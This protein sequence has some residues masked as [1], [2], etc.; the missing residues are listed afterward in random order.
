MEIILS[1]FRDINFDWLA[2]YQWLFMLI[3][4]IIGAFFILFLLSLAVWVYRDIRTRSRDPLAIAFFILLVL[5]LN[6]PGL[7]F[8]L[9]LRPAETL[10]ES[11]ERSLHEEALLRELDDQ[12]S[13]PSCQ[14]PIEAEFIMCPFCYTQ[15]KRPCPSCRRLL[16]PSWRGCP[17]CGTRVAETPSDGGQT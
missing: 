3:A 13:C 2:Q 7:V 11:Y 8:Y 14:R 17:Y 6:L 9:L 16:S 1:L 4:A 10:A 12:V 15:L 5:I